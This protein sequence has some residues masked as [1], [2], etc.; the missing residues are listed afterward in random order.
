MAAQLNRSLAQWRSQLQ[1]E[2]YEVV[3]GWTFSADNDQ[4]I[5]VTFDRDSVA[6]PG[7]MANKNANQ[8]IRLLLEVEPFLY[9]IHATLETKSLPISIIITVTA[10]AI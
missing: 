1:M 9:R 8:L 6:D 4:P 5:H 7:S 2:K 3:E 10:R